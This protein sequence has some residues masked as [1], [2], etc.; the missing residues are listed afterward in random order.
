MSRVVVIG[1]PLPLIVVVVVVV[2]VEPPDV[3][4]LGVAL[5]GA[6]VAALHGNALASNWLHHWLA[7]T[8]LFGPM[9]TGG[10]DALVK[11]CLYNPLSASTSNQNCYVLTILNDEMP[12]LWPY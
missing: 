1:A 10:C 9:T 4:S 12:V 8:S 2:V 7:N 11:S 5:L 6:V 3:L